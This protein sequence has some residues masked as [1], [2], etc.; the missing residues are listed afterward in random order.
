MIA[1]PI[2]TLSKEQNEPIAQQRASC[3]AALPGA[4]VVGDAATS[5]LTTTSD[6]GVGGRTAASTVLSD[7]GAATVPRL[8]LP[9]RLGGCRPPTWQSDAS[10]IQHCRIGVGL[11]RIVVCSPASPP[12]THARAAAKARPSCAESC[13]DKKRYMRGRFSFE[14]DLTR[15]KII[16]KPDLNAKPRGVQSP[17]RASA[18]RA[19]ICPGPTSKTQK[20]PS[21]FANHCRCRRRSPTLAFQPLLS[22]PKSARRKTIV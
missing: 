9:L 8:R 19:K 11:K 18:S 1:T 17:S 3:T 13:S 6:L 7:P 15:L 16:R 14:T 21:Q 12:P 4:G 2:T 10:T 5:A 22:A 20:R